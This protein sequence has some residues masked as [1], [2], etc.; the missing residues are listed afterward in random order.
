MK[1]KRLIGK[2]IIAI[3]VISVMT[4]VTTG[5]VYASP[6]DD[7]DGTITGADGAK[8]GVETLLGTVLTG[9]RMVGAG[10]AICILSY[11]GIKYML[12]S[13]S[14]RAELKNYLIKY[15]IGAVLLI[16]ATFIV[17]QLVEIAQDITGS[18]AIIRNTIDIFRLG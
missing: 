2:M 18:T 17:T 1:N 6:L 7:F 10:M 8:S 3:L 9:V 16:S 5:I 11:V 14:E 13:A 15:V 12:A 4:L